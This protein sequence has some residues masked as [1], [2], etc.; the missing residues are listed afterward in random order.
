MVQEAPNVLI[1]FPFIDVT[2][3]CNILYDEFASSFHKMLYGSAENLLSILE[4]INIWAMRMKLKKV[5]VILIYKIR[6]L[7]MFVISII[8]HINK[9][10]STLPPEDLQS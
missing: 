4:E 3:L 7:K 6:F 10:F 5:N 2:K 1:C 8:A 9:T